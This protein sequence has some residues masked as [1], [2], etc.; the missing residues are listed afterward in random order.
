MNDFKA[1]M[2][3]Y[4][5]GLKDLVVKLIVKPADF[6]RDMPRTG[7][8]LDPLIFVLLAS[9][10]GV[11]LNAIELLMTSG[12]GM[13]MVTVWLITVPIVMVIM[14]FFVAG[15]CYAAWAFMGSKENF[16]TSYRCLA[17]MQILFPIMILV[18]IV[19]YL[20]LACIAWWLYLMV[21]ATREVHKVSVKP[22]LAVFGIIAAIVGLIYYSSVS[23][24]MKSKERI[25]EY[26]KELQKMPG[27]NDMG[28]PANR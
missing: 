13:G 21:I 22:A 18:S 12:V 8:I 7:G 1:T 24:T 25:E 19:P 6:F 2:Q 11:V 5:K 23:S 10:L 20:G 15:I 17:Y 16:E 3:S 9:L 14:S 4:F 28:N 26:T 27:A